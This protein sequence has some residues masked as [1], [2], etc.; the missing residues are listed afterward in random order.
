MSKLVDKELIDFVE[1]PSEDFNCPICLGILQEPYLTACCGNHFCEVCIDN[2][3]EGNN[4]CP[5]CQTMPFNGVINKHFKRKI[6]ELEVYCIHKQDGCKWKGE[7]GNLNQHLAVDKIEGECQF[8]ILKCP[9]SPSCGEVIARK[10]LTHHI[11]SVC[12]Y[13]QFACEYCGFLSTYHVVTIQHIN[14]CVNYPMSC[15]NECSKQTYPRSQLKNHLATC[16]EQMVECDFKEIG[17]KVRMKRHLMQGHLENNLLEHQMIMCKAFKS[18]QKDK[19]EL[20]RKVTLEVARSSSEVDYWV[21]GFKLVATAM[22]EA[23]WPLYISKMAEITAMQPIAPL[24]YKVTLCIIREQ[25]NGECESSTHYGYRRHGSLHSH[26]HYKALLYNSRPF[27][28]HPNGYKM[29]FTVE[30]VCL[31][32]DCRARFF[33]LKKDSFAMHYYN[34]DI[35]TCVLVN[36]YLLHGEYDTQLKWPFESNA[37]ITLLNEQKNDAHQKVAKTYVGNKNINAKVVKLN[38]KQPNQPRGDRLSQVKSQLLDYRKDDESLK[39]LFQEYCTYM[40]PDTICFA[41]NGK[42]CIS[43]FVCQPDTVYCTNFSGECE[44]DFFFKIKFT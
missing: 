17:C 9:L 6:N 36:L 44:T 19:E 2:V 35:T 43:K 39:E 10:T 1:I 31:C 8:V 28:S 33:G 12:D 22:K 18:L 11:N 30:F 41:F 23:D 29:Q 14:K 20:E 7:Y 16:P 27:Y 25:C 34:F 3:K 37:T 42:K 5:L 21:K 40:K 15:P 24:I 4:K 26:S 32:L 13:R 38:A